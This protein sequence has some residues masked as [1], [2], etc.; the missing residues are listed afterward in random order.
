M[1]KVKKEPV[2]VNT[3]PIIN[4]ENVDINLNTEKLTVTGDI[5]NILKDS[6]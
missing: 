6:E 1:D 3:T 5:K 4:P 2:V